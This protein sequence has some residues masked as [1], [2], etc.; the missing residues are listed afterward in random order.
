MILAEIISIKKGDIYQRYE[1]DGTYD[2]V[3]NGKYFGLSFRVPIGF[4]RFLTSKDYSSF[5]Y[6][7][8]LKI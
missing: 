4:F 3:S 6:L 1:F 7:F 8:I 5:I 2:T